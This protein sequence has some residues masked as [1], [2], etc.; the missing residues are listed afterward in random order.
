MRNKLIQAHPVKANQFDLKYSPGGM[1]DVEFVVQFLV[2]A[3][4][5][6]FPQLT[7]NTG[8]IALLNTASTLGLISAELANRCINAYKNYRHAQHLA[9]LDDR[10]LKFD[11]DTFAQDSQC[12]LKLWKAIFDR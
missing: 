12:V 1:I 9:R 10:N 5:C 8:N 6:K 4:S 11:T 7:E 2:L 3:Y